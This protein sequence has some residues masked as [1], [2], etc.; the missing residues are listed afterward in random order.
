M[1]GTPY[2]VERTITRR[3]NPKT[4]IWV[5]AGLMVSG[6]QEGSIH[7]LLSYDWFSSNLIDLICI[8]LLSLEIISHIY[9]ADCVNEIQKK[10]NFT[11]GLKRGKLF[12]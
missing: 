8:I 5:A 10:H 7:S 9:R 11:K 12:L 1:L 4:C 3:S 6:S 2:R